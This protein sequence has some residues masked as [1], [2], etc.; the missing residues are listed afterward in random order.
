MSAAPHHRAVFDMIVATEESSY[1]WH[2]LDA[3]GALPSD[4]RSIP[5]LSS[6]EFRL[7]RRAGSVLATQAKLI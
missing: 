1:Q 3:Q 6:F 4:S 5:L 2:S 7:P